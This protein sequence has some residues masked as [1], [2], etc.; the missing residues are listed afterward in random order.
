MFIANIIIKAKERFEIW[1]EEMW[2]D[3]ICEF[4][5]RPNKRLLPEAFEKED[6]RWTK[7]SNSKNQMFQGAKMFKAIFELFGNEK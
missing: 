2:S 3:L 4:F 6:Y 7:V 5:L 1:C